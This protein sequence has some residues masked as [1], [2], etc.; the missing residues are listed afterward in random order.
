MPQLPEGL[1]ECFFL[2]T[3]LSRYIWA[4]LVSFSLLSSE[5]SMVVVPNTPRWHRQFLLFHRAL[6]V[7]RKKFPLRSDRQISGFCGCSRWPFAAK[8]QLGC[9]LSSNVQQEKDIQLISMLLNLRFW[10]HLGFSF[11]LPMTHT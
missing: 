4:W 5:T 2:S 8:V 11:S 9:N 3:L 1:Q 10:S 6:T 7:F